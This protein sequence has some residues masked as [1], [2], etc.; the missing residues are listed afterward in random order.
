M[1]RLRNQTP[2]VVAVHGATGT[3]GA[4]IVRRLLG[5]GHHVRAIARSPDG[6][7]AECEPFPADPLTIDQLTRAYVRAD[8]VVVQLPL[9]FDDRAST[10]PST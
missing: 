9:T 3:Q 1:R 8:A 6:L 4:P 5:D 7:P 2:T 10:T